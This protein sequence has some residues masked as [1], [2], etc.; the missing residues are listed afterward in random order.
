MIRK[1]RSEAFRSD[2]LAKNDFEDMIPLQEKTAEDPFINKVIHPFAVYSHSRQQFKVLQ[3]MHKRNN[4]TIEEIVGFL[5]ATG[6]VVKVTN[7]E[8]PIF[9]YPLVVRLKSN[10]NEN[11]TIF[12]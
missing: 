4:K 3:T 11:F 2:D 9:Y 7:E 6:N 5:D 1:V 10:N 12:P 8:R